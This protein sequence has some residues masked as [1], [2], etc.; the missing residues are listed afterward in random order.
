[1]LSIQS[2]TGFENFRPE[3]NWRCIDHFALQAMGF[4]T[5]VLPVSQSSVLMDK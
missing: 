3:E 5:V 4:F 2:M 1:M